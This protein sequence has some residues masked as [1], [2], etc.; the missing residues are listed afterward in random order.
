MVVPTFA[1]ALLD[2]TG[3]IS[4]VSVMSVGHLTMIP[5]M[6]AVMLL[7]FDRYAGLKAAA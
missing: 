5:A 7:R 4:V 6:L 3:A 2:L 1:A